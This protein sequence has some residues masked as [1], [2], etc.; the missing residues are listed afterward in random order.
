MMM[1]LP[2]LSSELLA[3]VA[4]SSELPALIRAF[5]IRALLDGTFRHDLP[6]KGF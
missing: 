6:I 3:R 2:L 4:L 1:N 5:A